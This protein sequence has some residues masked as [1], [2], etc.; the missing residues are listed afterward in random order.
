MLADTDAIR[1]LG[2][3]CSA[4]AEDLAVIATTLSS[5]PD[6]DAALGP[7][8]ARFLAS[9]ADAVAHES[10]AVAALAERLAAAT[11]TAHTA[12]VAYDSADGRAGNLISRV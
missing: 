12:A 5:I 4:Q 3:A 7:V 1:F 2:A 8:G 11:I 9:L 6:S 10:R